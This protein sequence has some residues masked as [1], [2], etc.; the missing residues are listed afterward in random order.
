MQVLILK[1]N[2]VSLLVTGA[3]SIN[4]FLMLTKERRTL[5]AA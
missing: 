2:Y 4:V 3:K 5:V 1:E